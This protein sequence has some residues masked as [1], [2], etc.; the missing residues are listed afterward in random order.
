MHSAA[1]DFALNL[2]GELS[3]IA[4]IFC[5]SFFWRRRRGRKLFNG[6]YMGD[7]VGRKSRTAAA[8]KLRE[9]FI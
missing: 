6:A 5:S 3:S 1:R 4:F 7:I 2:S 9:I 8:G